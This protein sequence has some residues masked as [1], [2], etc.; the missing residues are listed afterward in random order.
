MSC[1]LGNKHHFI[2]NVQYVSTD[3]ATV[4]YE[5]TYG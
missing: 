5:P 1:Y 3:M 2:V 4:E